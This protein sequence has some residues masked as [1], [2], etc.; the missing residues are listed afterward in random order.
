MGLLDPTRKLVK[1][2][3]T[4][5]S[6]FKIISDSRMYETHRLMVIHPWTKYGKSMSNPKSYGP[7]TN[8]HTQTDRQSDSY[9]PPGTSFTGI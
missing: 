8:L 4:L 1:N 9:K 7:D 2:P 3:M 5:R 6:K